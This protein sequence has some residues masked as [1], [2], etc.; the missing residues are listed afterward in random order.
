MAVV[1]SGMCMLIQA[2]F[3]AVK[4]NPFQIVKLSLGQLT[5]VFQAKTYHLPYQNQE[6]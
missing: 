1:K 6:F 4:K 2:P 5:T 3:G